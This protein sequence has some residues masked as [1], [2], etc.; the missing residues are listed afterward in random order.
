M[1]GPTAS[2]LDGINQGKAVPL[3]MYLAQ[4]LQ[5]LENDSGEGGAVVVQPLS[6]ANKVSQ[7]ISN[8]VSYEVATFCFQIPNLCKNVFCGSPYPET[9]REGI[10][11]NYY[12]HNK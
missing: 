12:Y 1:S 7:G 4:E 2:D 5:K 11:S 9:H 6:H 8:N 3:S 10:L